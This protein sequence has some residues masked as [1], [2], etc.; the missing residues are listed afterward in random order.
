[1]ENTHMPQ[2]LNR[3]RLDAVQMLLD[4]LVGS[5]TSTGIELMQMEQVLLLL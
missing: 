3:L 4:I 2:A 5:A 1:M